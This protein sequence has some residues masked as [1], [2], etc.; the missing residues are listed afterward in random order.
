MLSLSEINLT[1][2]YKHNMT[3][4]LCSIQKMLNSLKQRV[5]WWLP[6]IGR[7]VEH[8]GQRIQVFI[9]SQSYSLVTIV[10][11]ALLNT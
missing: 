3:S 11:D 5:E 2:K 6:G 9:I 7:K 1:Q 8:I 10:H 4:L